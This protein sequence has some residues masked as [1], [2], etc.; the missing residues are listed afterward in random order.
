MTT[1]LEAFNLSASLVLNQDKS[2]FFT[3]DCYTEDGW[4]KSD[5]V[6]I[7]FHHGVL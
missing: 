1:V 5:L 3:I 4:I 6:S 7:Q 2:I